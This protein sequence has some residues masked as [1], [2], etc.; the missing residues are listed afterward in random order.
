MSQDK[1]IVGVG[2]SVAVGI[3]VV[4]GVGIGSPPPP[5][6]SPDTSKRPKSNTRAILVILIASPLP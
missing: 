4:V 5:Q 1:N 2:V 3:G 6:A